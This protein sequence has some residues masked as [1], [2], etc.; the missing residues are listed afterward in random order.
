M[1]L[2]RSQRWGT[3]TLLLLLGAFY[4]LLRLPRL[5]A[6]P[7]FTDEA[8]YLRWAQLIAEDPHRFLWVSM[9]DAK[10][11]LHYW[12][13][14]LAFPW[15]KDPV[16]AGRLLSVL[17][18][19]LTIPALFALC[20]ELA[21]LHPVRRLHPL[22]LATVASLV[23]I[24]SPFIAFQQRLAIAESLLI[25]EIILLA[26]L[27]LRFAR[28]AAAAPS[29]QCLTTALLLG[30]TW[31][32]MLLTKQ[33]FSYFCWILPFAALAARG[34]WWR[35]STAG[36][37]RRFL[38][39]ILLA[40]AL[41]LAA[42]IPILFTSDR[43]DWFTKLFYKP[44]FRQAGTFSRWTIAWE[45]II[46]LLSPRYDRHAQW[47]PHDPMC[48]LQDGWY[49]VFLTPPVFLALFVG[50]VWLIKQRQWPILLFLGAWAAATLGILLPG[51]GVLM[52]RY[53]IT[54]TLPL[55]L[56]AAWGIA[57]ATWRLRS[58][59]PSRAALALPAAALTL[60]LLWPAWAV[61]KAAA[62]WRAPLMPEKDMRQYVSGSP[63]GSA[64]E[65]ALAW[66]KTQSA[67]SPLTLITGNWIGLPNDLIWLGAHN[68]P[69][70]ALFWYDNKSSPR[71]RQP[72]G[73]PDL[74]ML[75]S[76]QWGDWQTVPVRLPPD[77]PIYLIDLAY[78]DRET[79]EMCTYIPLDQLPLGAQVV[80]VFTNPPEQPGGI[81]Q[82]EVLLIRLP[83]LSAPAL[84]RP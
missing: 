67:Q 42:F 11:P 76:E 54:G 6:M 13:L 25:L 78:R 23:F 65:A 61:G 19:L 16:W 62:D 52:S 33:V 18:G 75:G 21:T 28:Q 9:E 60:L 36:T 81:H 68:D 38:T 20:R 8:T 63:N 59:V 7:V 48:P 50:V 46:T 22:W 47:W 49:Y 1:N 37:L 53:L 64:S 55:L 32:A 31:A 3:W 79:H 69:R 71:L 12:L 41:G 56:I 15:S 57:D 27:A 39:G 73:R 84:A 17:F 45:N 43:H 83:S 24:C 29:R 2:P 72:P 70:I 40:T 58:L 30:L 4:L 14:A 44:A 80:Q 77:R 66:V 35:G 51:A 74:V 5:R 10:L 26:W 34:G 82:S